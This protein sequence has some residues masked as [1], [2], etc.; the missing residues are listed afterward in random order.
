MKRRDAQGRNPA[1]FIGCRFCGRRPVKVKNGRLLAH[2][3]PGNVACIGAGQYA[4]LA[5][6]KGQPV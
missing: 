6:T 4:A 3:S 1:A 2:P 5:R